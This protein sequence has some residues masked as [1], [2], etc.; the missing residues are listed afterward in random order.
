[1]IHALLAAVV[2]GLYPFVAPTPRVSR[3]GVFL[4]HFDRGG[5]V[6]VTHS[7]DDVQVA[8]PWRRW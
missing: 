7:S 6:N 3:H 5:R 2:L 4:V 1:L 8:P